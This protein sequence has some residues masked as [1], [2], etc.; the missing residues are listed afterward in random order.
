MRRIKVIHVPTTTAGGLGRSVLLMAKGLDPARYEVSVAFG[1][2]YPMDQWFV[3]AGFRVFRVRMRR[4]L[5]PVNLLGLWDLFRLFRRESF[6]VVHAHS[7]VAGVL[8]RLAARLSGVPVVIFTL[9]GYASLDVRRSAL[10]P[11]LWMVEKLMDRFTDYYAAICSDVEQTWI[12]RGIVSPERVAVI[13]NGVDPET[14]CRPIDPD[15]KRA[16]LNIPLNAPIIG[17]IGRLEPQKATDH[18]VRVFPSILSVF[19]DAHLVIV[20][21]G[22][23][24][25][26][27]CGLVGELG[28]SARVHLLGWR[29][30][31][32]DL[33]AIMDVFCLP[34]LREGFSVALLE[35]MAHARP[36]VCTRVAGNPE[37]V[38]DGETGLLVPVADPAALSKALLELLREREIAR[39]MGRR[40]R[41]RLIQ[42]FTARKMGEEYSRLYERV[43]RQRGLAL[44]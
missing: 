23:L 8:A 28:L 12:A 29:E 27:T 5:H 39:E 13:Y 43:V 34:S 31:A 11:F 41:E 17:T 30:D 40:G 25:R 1:P 20:G 24:Y 33:I 4:G 35:A 15:A 14:V 9:H 36:I 32:T 38:A 6:D 44:E 19:P 16:E 18:L 2:G 26:R 7:S 37:A 42:R 22:P 21:N 10:R 3:E